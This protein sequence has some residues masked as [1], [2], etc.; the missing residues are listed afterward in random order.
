MA[1]RAPDAKDVVVVI[2]RSA[3]MNTRD[4]L[5]NSNS[6]LDYAKDAASAVIDTL[7]PTD[8]VFLRIHLTCKRAAMYFLVN[9]YINL[10]QRNINSSSCEFL[11]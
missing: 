8:R 3:S 9:L 6:R 1:T 7:S 10:Y 2:D 11:M 5:S 4:S